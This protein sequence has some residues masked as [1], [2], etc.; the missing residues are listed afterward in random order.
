MNGFGVV[1]LV[2]VLILAGLAG[3]MAVSLIQL[4]RAVRRLQ[5]R[6]DRAAREAGR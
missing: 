4:D 3:G 5:T 2:L 6:E 1:G